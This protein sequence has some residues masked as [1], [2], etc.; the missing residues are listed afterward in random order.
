[1]NFLYEPGIGT[2]FNG[3]HGIRYRIVGNAN[4]IPAAPRYSTSLSRWLESSDQT[5]LGGGRQRKR[6]SRK[7]DTLKPYQPHPWLD[8]DVAGAQ[9]REML[10]RDGWQAADAGRTPSKPPALAGEKLEAEL[11]RYFVPDE[12]RLAIG[13]GRHRTERQK[14]LIRA[15]QVFIA[16][17]NPRIEALADLIGVQGRKRVL[18]NYEKEGVRLMWDELKNDLRAEI[19]AA[20]KESSDD[21]LRVILAALGLD[22]VGEAEEALRGQSRP[23]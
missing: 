4:D 13:A 9:R 12:L 15:L 10:Q 16:L 5:P 14:E 19:R 22:P 18:Y 2:I 1:M 11:C 3:S 17:K 7:S 6:L 21:Q 20:I 8:L 23:T